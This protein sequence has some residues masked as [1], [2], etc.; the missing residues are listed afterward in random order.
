[1][2]L[3]GEPGLGAPLI[4]AWEIDRARY[5]ATPIMSDGSRGPTLEL[6]AL[7]EQF[8]LETAQ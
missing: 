5:T 7:Y 3:R 4:R 8:L 6:R 2:G 1:M